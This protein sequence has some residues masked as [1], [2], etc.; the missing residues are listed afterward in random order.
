MK[1]KTSLFTHIGTFDGYIKNLIEVL[2]RLHKCI[3]RDRIYAHCSMNKQYIKRGA[4][5]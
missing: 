1:R 4:K 3:Q 5:K 2:P